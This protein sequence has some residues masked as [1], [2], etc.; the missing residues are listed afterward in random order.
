M[1]AEKI[2]RFDVL[3][4][5]LK[6]LIALRPD[7]AHAYNA[8]GY[9]FADRNLR[10]AEAHEL[11]EKALKLAPE[12]FFIMDSMGWVLYRMGNL[13]ESVKY[14]QRAFSGR[15]DPEIAAHLGEVLWI[16]GKRTEA[17]KILGDAV[18]KYP[19]NEAL[20]NTIQRLKR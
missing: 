11:I 9:T 6:K 14:L 12:D 17:E 19:N 10:L 3:E 8:L 13:E 15:A 5:S 20:N 16:S 2:E 18:Q 4:S 1:L 7:H